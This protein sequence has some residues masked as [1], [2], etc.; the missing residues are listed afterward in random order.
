[1]NLLEAINKA[2]QVARMYDNDTYIVIWTDG[3][4]Y[5][6]VC[7][8]ANIPSRNILWSFKKFQGHIIIA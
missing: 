7:K 3:T 8:L 2:M 5:Y 6:N 4:E 1:M